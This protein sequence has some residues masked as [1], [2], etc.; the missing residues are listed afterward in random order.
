MTRLRRALRSAREATTGM[1]LV[2]LTVTVALMSTVMAIVSGGIVMAMRLMGSN[3]LRLEEIAENRVAIEAMTKTLRTAVQPRLLGSSSE[4]AAFI[5]GDNSRV[6]FYAALSSLVEPTSAE[7]TRS[8]PVRISYAL[9]GGALTETYQLPDAHL[10][11]DHDFTYCTPGATGCEVRT[12]VLATHVVDPHLFT[13]YSESG[14]TLGVPLS[15]A[16]LEAVDSIDMVLAS[17]TGSDET[18]TVTSRV[19]LVNSGS[20]PTASPTA[21]P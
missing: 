5:Q 9:S 16:G 10:P 18:S 17:Q 14:G 6:T 2:E 21:S 15:T 13:Y 11:S 3:S 12:R 19:S 20:G 8:G 4:D 7:L 1:T